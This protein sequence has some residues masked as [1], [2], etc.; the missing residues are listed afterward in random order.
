MLFNPDGQLM[1]QAQAK[2]QIDSFDFTL[3]IAIRVPLP[4][5]F[6]LNSRIVIFARIRDFNPG[7]IKLIKL[8]Y[9]GTLLFYEQIS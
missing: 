6:S 4:K 2:F 7:M 3:T 1:L 8:M 9:C 5:M